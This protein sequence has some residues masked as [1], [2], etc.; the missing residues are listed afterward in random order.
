MKVR[1]T[2]SSG[3]GM[4]WALTSSPTRLAASAP[5]STAARTLPTSPRTIVVT[6]A[7]PM[8]TRPTSVTLAALSIES[9][10]SM[11]PTRPL[12][13]TSPSAS[14][15]KAWPPAAP[16]GLFFWR[17]AMVSGSVVLG[18]VGLG[19]GRGRLGEGQDAGEVLVGAGDDLDAHDLADPAGRGGPGVDGGL[20]G[21][22]V[23][24]HE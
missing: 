15:F 21:R 3:R 6:Y 16:R 19:G 12:V 11:T 17:V 13:S 18:G 14:P 4:T 5:A 23:A 7:A 9:V 1:S 10:A 2:A 20:H 8:P 22:D 24:G